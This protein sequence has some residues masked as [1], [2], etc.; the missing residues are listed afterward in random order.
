[1]M[2]RAPVYVLRE[3]SC[4]TAISDPGSVPQYTDCG[5]DN[6]A[7]DF[8]LAIVS[9]PYQGFGE[10]YD[11]PAEAL[12]NGTLFAS[13]NFPILDANGTRGKGGCIL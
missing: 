8:P 10:V 6:E 4:E 12:K 9:A 13:L 2:M 5:N 3:N 1:M 7:S 11:C